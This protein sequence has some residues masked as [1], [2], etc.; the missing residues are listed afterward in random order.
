MARKSEELL[1]C[2]HAVV[3]AQKEPPGLVTSSLYSYLASE[4]RAWN[5]HNLGSQV[6]LL[7]DTRPGLGGTQYSAG[8]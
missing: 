7:G 8:L 5:L 3:Y 6:S 1:P 2:G 4:T